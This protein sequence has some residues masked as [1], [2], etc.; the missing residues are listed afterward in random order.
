MSEF[1][2]NLIREFESRPGFYD[3]NSH[4][5]K[6][7]I[8]NAQAWQDISSIL[9]YDV[10]LLKDRMLQ[11]RN[12]YNLE[13]RRLENLSEEYPDK[14][15][16]SQWPLYEHL[17]FL[18]DHIRPRRSYKRMITRPSGEFHN[19]ISNQSSSSGTNNTNNTNGITTVKL[20]NEYEDDDSEEN[21]IPDD[22]EV[23]M[24]CDASNSVC[25][26]D[27]PPVAPAPLTLKPIAVKNIE[28]MRTIVPKENI[29]K[30]PP[31]EPPIIREKRLC[32]ESTT[33]VQKFDAFGKF[34]TSS[35]IELPPD[36]ALKLVEKFTSDI[37]KV[38]IEKNHSMNGDR[39]EPVNIS[40]DDCH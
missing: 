5:F 8:Y 36:K 35:L 23:D 4:H 22:G 33:R 15:I 9:G 21:S 19:S 40:D 27:A 13:K 26:D 32:V 18:S 25:N 17:H 31:S 1:D 29:R 10:A 38:L 20:E 37:V 24:N 39:K 6:D 34:V 7:K 16:Q 11:L 2:V 30:I 3:R 28:S 14:I 12:R